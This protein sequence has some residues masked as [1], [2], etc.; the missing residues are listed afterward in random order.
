MGEKCPYVNMSVTKTSAGQRFEEERLRLGKTQEDVAELS[1]VTRRTI[2]RIENGENYANGDLL[3]ALAENGFDAQY[4]ITG[5]R[6]TNLDRVAEKSGTYDASKKEKGVGA[7]SQEEEAL[8]EKYRHLKPGDR[9]RAQAIVD[10]LVTTVK[11][12]EAG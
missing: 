1:G 3:E 2:S 7:L 9:T 6:S 11:K 4:I 5:I 10:A 8:I 12:K